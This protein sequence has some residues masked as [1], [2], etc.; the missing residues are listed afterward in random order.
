MFKFMSNRKRQRKLEF[1]DWFD[2]L[3]DESQQ[4]TAVKYLRKLD[5]FSL[6]RLYAAV[7]LY[8][9]GDNELR[10]VKEPE[11]DKPSE[12]PDDDTNFVETNNK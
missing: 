4:E 10:K 2:E 8:R 12:E 1:Q 7:D 11:D 9:K 3:D 5:N 6:K